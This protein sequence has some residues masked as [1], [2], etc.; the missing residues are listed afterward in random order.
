MECIH[1]SHD[2][3]FDEIV[4]PF[5]SLHSNVGARLCQEIELLPL[6]LQPLNLH[7]HEGHELQRPIDV[8]PA[9][10]TDGVPEYFFAGNR[11]TFYV[12]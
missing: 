9:N 11:T 10:A 7:Y 3:V 5:A 12:R 1:I 8:N 2:I 4:F 6:S